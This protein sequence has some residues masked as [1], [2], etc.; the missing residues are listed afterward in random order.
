MLTYEKILE[1]NKTLIEEQTILIV[2]FNN[3][4]RIPEKGLKGET[5]QLEGYQESLVNKYP[6]NRYTKLYQKA[7]LINSQ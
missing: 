5:P 7:Y 1:I 6:N 3:I 4:F 2:D